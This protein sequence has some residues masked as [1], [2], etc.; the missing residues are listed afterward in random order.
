MR[1]PDSLIV[2]M[3]AFAAGPT[4][5]ADLI[6]PAA[7]PGEFRDDVPPRA[8]ALR[9]SYALAVPFASP[10]S[11]ALHPAELLEA[12]ATAA[13]LPEAAACGKAAHEALLQGR[14]AAL[15]AGGQGEVFDPRT[16]RT[17]PAG[18][19][20]GTR[21]L[22]EI[23]GRGGCWSEPAPTVRALPLRPD[24]GRRTALAAE[25]AAVADGRLQGA[26]GVSAT[27]PLILVLEDQALPAASGALPPVINKLYRESNFLGHPGQVEIHPRTAGH[28]GCREGRTVRLTTPL[29][30]LP[31]RIGLDETVQPGVVRMAA[32]PCS[33]DLG[34]EGPAD[35]APSLCG[36][37][38]RPVWRI[39]RA[40]I[41]EV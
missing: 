33:Q 24:P 29:G 38:I 28:L 27:Y 41:Q 23:L 12:L 39:T 37:G 8:L 34:D 4:R 13:G 35:G 32:I 31:V 15:A 20:G 6:I 3:S 21:P 19:V 5:E 40:A 30:S 22:M 18:S 17:T 26:E 1:G 36:A 11:C 9:N 25:L 10:P 16:G 7:A 14:A 2:G